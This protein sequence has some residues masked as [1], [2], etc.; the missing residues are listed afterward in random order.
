MSSRAYAAMVESVAAAGRAV[1]DPPLIAFRQGGRSQVD[2]TLA[3]L[4]RDMNRTVLTM[5][6]ETRSAA[7]DLENAFFFGTVAEATSSKS[8]REAR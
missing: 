7:Y 2:L 4:A 1:D 8:N 3:A 5:A 6:A